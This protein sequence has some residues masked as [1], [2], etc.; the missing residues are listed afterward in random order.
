[1][2]ESRLYHDDY[3]EVSYGLQGPFVIVVAWYHDGHEMPK[4]V[5][6]FVDFEALLRLF[7]GD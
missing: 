3:P 6:V 7:V 1:M 4:L 2:V 5:K